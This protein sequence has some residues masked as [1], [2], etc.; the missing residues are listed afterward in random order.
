[1]S[2]RSAAMAQVNVRIDPGVKAAGD[3]TLASVDVTATQLIRA[4]WDKLAQGAS[5]FDQLAIA[6][7][8]DSPALA[9]DRREKED[10]ARE[11]IEGIIQRQ[12]AFEKTWGL[13]ASTYVALSDEEMEDLLFDERMQRERAREAFDGS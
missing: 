12:E 10:A 9:S 5:A 13:D 8:K 11:L 2:A 6:L 3:A 1:M 7:A 4:V